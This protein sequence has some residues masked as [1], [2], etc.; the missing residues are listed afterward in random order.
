[1]NSRQR[2][3]LEAIFA[4]PTNGNIDWSLIESL[5]KAVGC[6]VI[7]GSG[8]SVTF[9]KDGKRAYFHRPHPARAALRYRVTAT[10]EFLEKVGAKP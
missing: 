7:E 8:S 1:M 5:L 2:K 6:R 4:E 3:T 9:E 10:R